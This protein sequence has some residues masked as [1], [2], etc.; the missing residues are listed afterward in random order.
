MTGQRSALWFPGQTRGLI[1]RLADSNA[2]VLSQKTRLDAWSALNTGYLSRR[3]LQYMASRQYW[4]PG[5]QIILYS[6]YLV[7]RWQWMPQW[8]TLI[9]ARLLGSTCTLPAITSLLPADGGHHQMR[10]LE[11]QW[12]TGQRTVLATW[13]KSKR[14]LLDT[15]HRVVVNTWLAE[16]RL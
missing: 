12:N 14:T 1:T 13:I 5:W 10:S 6:E 15:D 11:Q 2:Q 9:A 7:N 3:Q 4:K 8:H 16:S